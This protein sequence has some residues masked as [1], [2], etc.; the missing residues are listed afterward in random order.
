MDKKLEQMRLAYLE[1]EDLRQEYRCLEERLNNPNLRGKRN[2]DKESLISEYQR[3]IAEQRAILEKKQR[4]IAQLEAKVRDQ[5]FEI[6]SLLQLE[7]PA[8]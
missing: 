2:W 3:T 5:L 4:H 1:F 7:V 6:R 8:G